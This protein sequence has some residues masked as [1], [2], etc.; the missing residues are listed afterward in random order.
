MKSIKL[1]L[2]A[3]FA[4]A[5]DLKVII[6]NQMTYYILIIYNYLIPNS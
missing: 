5:N 4:Y 2:E 6:P 1:I 3:Q